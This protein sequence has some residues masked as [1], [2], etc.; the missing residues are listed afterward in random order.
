MSTPLVIH[1][2]FHLHGINR[3]RVSLNVPAPFGLEEPLLNDLRTR[4]ETCVEVSASGFNQMLVLYPWVTGL[5]NHPNPFSINMYQRTDNW[6]RR[7]PH[8]IVECCE[9]GFG[10]ISVRYCLL[11][12]AIRYLRL[13]YDIKFSPGM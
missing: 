9:C 12:F 1:P 5:I 10:R 3:V 6:T 7:S 11:V 8:L 4:S 13:G 2:Q